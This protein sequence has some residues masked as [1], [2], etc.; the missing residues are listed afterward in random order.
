MDFEDINQKEFEGFMTQ[1]KP[2][3]RD[4]NKVGDFTYSNPLTSIAY[5]A[6]LAG[7]QSKHA[8]IEHRTQ[9]SAELAGELIRKRAE[10]DAL[11]DCIIELVKQKNKSNA[12]LDNIQEIIELKTSGSFTSVLRK[13]D[14]ISEELSK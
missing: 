8:E 14:A 6:Y 5:D 2:E 11:Q 7:Q 10:I 3:F 12:K 1:Y 9:V 4:F 13:I